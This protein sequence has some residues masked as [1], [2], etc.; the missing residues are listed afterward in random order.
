MAVEK[1]KKVII[2][3]KASLKVREPNFCGPY[4]RLVCGA[5]LIVPD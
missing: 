2:L 3:E 4:C 5:F 1:T